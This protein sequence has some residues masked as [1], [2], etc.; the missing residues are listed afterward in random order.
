MTDTDKTQKSRET[1]QN[2]YPNSSDSLD[3]NLKPRLKEAHA[4]N[5]ANC[6]RVG[7]LSPTHGIN[8]PGHSK[9]LIGLIK[10]EKINIDQY[11]SAYR[12]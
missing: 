8:V 4:C 11:K 5:C 7:N 2:S 6:I 10:A 9:R 12:Q 3:W 1:Q